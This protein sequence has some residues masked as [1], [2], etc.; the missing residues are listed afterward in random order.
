MYGGGAAAA[1]PALYPVSTAAKGPSK[2]GLGVGPVGG[3]IT[4]SVFVS[5]PVALSKLKQWIALPFV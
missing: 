3:G 2:R 5:C 4:V 1:E